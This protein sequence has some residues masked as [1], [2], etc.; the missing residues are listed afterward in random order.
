ML[1]PQSL[2]PVART[3]SSALVRSRIGLQAM[4]STDTTSPCS[5][6]RSHRAA[7]VSAT[8]ERDQSSSSP[9]LDEVQ[10]T[11]TER[12][13]DPE[14]VGF[15]VAIEVGSDC[16]RRRH[17][18]GAMSTAGP[19]R[20]PRRRCPRGSSAG[21][22]T[23]RPLCE[24]IVEV[25]RP[26]RDEAESRCACALRRACG[27]RHPPENHRTDRNPSIEN[28]GTPRLRSSRHRSPSGRAPPCGLAS[29]S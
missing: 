14:E 6:A 4:N 16:R 19:A 24:R 15:V 27:S 8:S 10:R 5:A 26:E 2:R 11:R 12:I 28:L 1:T 18:R 23:L 22:A 17:R 7:S 29:Q 21:R 25:T 13:R 9:E 3:S 20:I